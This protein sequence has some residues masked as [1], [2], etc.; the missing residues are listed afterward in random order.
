MSLYDMSKGPKPLL[1][2]VGGETRWRLLPLNIIQ[3]YLT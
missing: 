2:F 1:R 3:A